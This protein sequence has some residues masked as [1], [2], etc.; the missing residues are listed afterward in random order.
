MANVFIKQVNAVKNGFSYLFSSVIAEPLMF[1]MPP[2]VGIELTNHCNLH[3]PE[4]AS[5]SGQMKRE[6]GFMNRELYDKILTEL[7]P[8]LFNINLFFQGEPMIHP[9]FFSLIDQ[10]YD[11]YSIV[12]TNGHFLTP[13]NAVRIVVS[14]LK[15]LIVSIDGM[16][17]NTY[18]HYRKDGQ[19]NVVMNGIR[20]VSSAIKTYNSSLKLELQFL[21]NRNNEHQIASVRLFASEINAT[22]KL[23]SMQIINNNDIEQWL[24][25]QD[26][27]RRY[28]EKGDSFVIRNP[29]PNR[30]FRLWTNP[31][32]TWDGKVLPCCFDKDADHI[33]GDLNHNS[34]REIWFGEK[35]RKYRQLILA[36]RGDI[37]I[38]R[39]CTSGIRG[40]K[41]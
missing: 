15:K 10:P 35:Y 41:T 24:P 37:D 36:S 29:M 4:C 22:L 30:C 38:C 7:N 12:S 19:L 26:K 11:L 18:S 17:Q 8:S 31:V 34:F 6:K 33:M 20:N 5:G 3:C 27:Y 2:A 21:V 14:K 25:V 40:V 23:K 16:D 39:N 1:G 13:D 9:D 32:I 28:K